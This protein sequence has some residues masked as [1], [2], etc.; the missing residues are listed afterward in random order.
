MA[1]AILLNIVK[2]ME[3]DLVTFNFKANQATPEWLTSVLIKNGFLLKGKVSSLEQTTPELA[4]SSFIATFV[5]LRVTYSP[6]SVGVKPQSIIIKI[7][8]PKY[9]EPEEHRE[10][11]FYNSV[12]D[13]QN[14]LPL[15]TCFG[16]EICPDTNQYCLLFED[17]TTTH[18]QSPS[19]VP[20]IQSECK[21][22][23]SA[24]ASIH[25]YWWNHSR[26]GDPLFIRPS[27]YQIEKYFHNF[28]N[29][30]PGF[31]DF[32]GDRISAKRKKIYK[33]VLEKA[34]KI[35]W[36]RLFPHEKQTISHGDAHFWNF[37][38]PNNKETDH[39]V[40]LDWQGW[41]I[42]LAAKDLAYMIAYRW[43]PER[44]QNLELPLLEF[45]FS[46]LSKYQINYTW[47]DLLVDYRICVIM[48]LILPVLWYSYNFAPNLWWNNFEKAFAS[49]EDLECMEF[50]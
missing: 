5:S 24:L 30:Y 43:L 36:D 11:N 4:T 2:R 44:R 46:E 16:T 31:V 19:P 26:F 1:L 23:I 21:E 8:K 50:L 37:L 38:Y 20:P 9:V 39:C 35:I 29:V 42:G 34:P 33:R 45:Y 10:L 7:I 25:G 14:E 32:L 22:A 48:N 49:F 3:N 15:L 12:F 27:E 28:A 47:D 17:L 13:V 18:H 6:G 40:M 41:E